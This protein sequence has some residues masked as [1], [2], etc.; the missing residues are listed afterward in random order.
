MYVQHFSSLLSINPAIP[1]HISCGACH[2]RTTPLR[3]YQ[4]L[5]QYYNQACGVHTRV[6]EERVTLTYHSPTPAVHK[7][8]TL[9]RVVHTSPSMGPGVPNKGKTKETYKYLHPT[10]AGPHVLPARYLVIPRKQQ[11]K[12]QRLNPRR[13]C[14]YKSL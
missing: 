10:G 9:T 3:L 6:E 13:S 12:T 11:R 14:L 1:K 7:G 5:H 2:R 4:K 8:S